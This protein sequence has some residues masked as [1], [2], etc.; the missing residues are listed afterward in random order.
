MDVSPRNPLTCAHPVIP[1]LSACRLLYLVTSCRNFCTKCGRSGRGPT[2]LMSPFK[3]LMNCGNSSRLVLRRIDPNIV[4]RES[5]ALVHT[6]SL[7]AFGLTHM[8]RNL[9]M[10]NG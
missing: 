1:T 6:T 7:S 2:T 4:F 10:P 8:V 3:T 5:S 9:Y